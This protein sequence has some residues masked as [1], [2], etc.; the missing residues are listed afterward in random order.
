MILELDIGNARAKWRLLSNDQLKVVSRG[1]ADVKEWLDGG[2]PRA[3]DV[4][5][6]RV[7]ASSVIGDALEQ[8]LAQRIQAS[9]ALR[10]EFARACAVQAGIINS[11][12]Q[13]QTLGVDRWLSLMAAWNR[14]KGAVLVAD[15]GSALTL[16]FADEEGVHRGGYIIPGPHLMQDALLRKTERVI[17]SEQLSMGGLSFGNN[18]SDCVAG[19]VAAAQ[20]GA[21]LIA[22][23]KT[24]VFQGEPVALFVTGG[25][26]EDLVN[27][28][29]EVDTAAECLLV[30]DLV[31]DGLRWALP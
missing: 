13:P 14:T 24:K 6:R 8:R 21:V 20:A 26:G 30:P 25:W 1:V 22:L 18:T 17:F 4:N 7:R 28:L 12:A 5:I 19:G 9:L 2:L 10:V 3:W 31:L 11:Y 16:D 15:I 29:T 27:S 23:E